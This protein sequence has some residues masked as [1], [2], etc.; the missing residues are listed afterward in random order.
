MILNCK[1]PSAELLLY[2]P[3]RILDKT[4]KNMTFATLNSMGIALKIRTSAIYVLVTLIMILTYLAPADWLG[5]AVL[6]L[7]VLGSIGV[8][9]YK[10]GGLVN[11]VESMKQDVG[12]IPGIELRLIAVEAKVDGLWRQNTTVSRSPM[13][14]NDVGHRII[15]SSKISELTDKYYDQIVRDVKVL[16]PPNPFQAQEVL[17]SIVKKFKDN[18]D[19]KERLERAAFNSGYDIDTVL[20]VAAINIRDRVII[21]LGFKMEDIDRH[22][23][24]FKA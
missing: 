23:P 8:L 22:D 24:K 7:S 16:N 21:D 14:L 4:K 18:E 13:I 2:N 20:F 9:I 5:I 10:A 11:L 17:I 15:E 6:V 1:G 19:C 3:S 12:K